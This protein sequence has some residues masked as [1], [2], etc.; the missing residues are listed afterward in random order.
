MRKIITTVLGLSGLGVL[1]QETP[2]LNQFN[3]IEDRFNIT[4]EDMSLLPKITSFTSS[5]ADMPNY[6]QLMSLGL[7]VYSTEL[8]QLNADSLNQ[9]F[10]PVDV[11]KKQMEL[12]KTHHKEAYAFSKAMNHGSLTRIKLD[13]PAESYKK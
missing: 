6:E 5:K 4:L 13:V 11:V 8:K 3:K 10:S 9:T 7:S 12:I 2:K 1:A